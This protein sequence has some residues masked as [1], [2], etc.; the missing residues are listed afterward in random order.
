MVSSW[1]GQDLS[2]L[3]AASCF[4]FYFFSLHLLPPVFDLPF[5]CGGCVGAADKMKKG[6][7]EEKGVFVFLPIFYF[8]I[9]WGDM[10]DI[11][12][13]TS[14]VMVFLGGG[15]GTGTG[16]GRGFVLIGH[17][18][19]STLLPRYTG[20]DEG[21]FR[22][23][24]RSL[25]RWLGFS[26]G[27]AGLFLYGATARIHETNESVC[28]VFVKVRLRCGWRWQQ[29]LHINGRGKKA[30]KT[31]SSLH[32]SAPQR[33]SVPRHRPSNSITATWS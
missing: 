8:C 19:L 30:L 15:T 22:T 6:G 26:S 12:S 14:H 2:C 23:R 28:S 21:D 1:A 11:Q 9:A 4:L 29:Q 3:S 10:G 25:I 18:P 16:F 27:L 31:L 17:T 5:F 20:E 24:N 13:H 33:L 32:G 7:M